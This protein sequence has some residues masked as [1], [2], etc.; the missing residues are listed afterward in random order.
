MNDFKVVTRFLARNLYKW[1]WKLPY[2]RRGF[3]FALYWFFLCFSVLN[4]LILLFSIAKAP[5][6]AWVTVAFL[7]GCVYVLKKRV[8]RRPRIRGHRIYQLPGRR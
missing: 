3:V 5:A 1:G 8:D 6:G 4:T 7:W 2:Q